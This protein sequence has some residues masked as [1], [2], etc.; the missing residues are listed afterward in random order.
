MFMDGRN[1]AR[2]LMRG[3]IIK[4]VKELEEAREVKEETHGNRLA[5][6]GVEKVC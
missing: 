1:A 6:E 4:E 5:R 3:S 2:P